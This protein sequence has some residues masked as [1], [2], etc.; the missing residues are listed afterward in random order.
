MYIHPMAG[1]HFFC[2]QSSS[3]F[4]GFCSSDMSGSFMNIYGFWV[5][6]TAV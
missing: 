6:I 3:F 2:I 1:R 4:S 5:E